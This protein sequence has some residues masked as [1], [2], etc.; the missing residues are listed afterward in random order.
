MDFKL[1]KEQEL[2]QKA[3]KEFAEKSLMPIADEIAADNHVSPEIFEE[4]AEPD[5]LVSSS[6]K[7]LEELEQDTP[8]IPW[9]WNRLP[10]LPVG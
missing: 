6:P 8:A 2:I 5:S 1:T 4:M 9:Y 7:N 10:G 3:A